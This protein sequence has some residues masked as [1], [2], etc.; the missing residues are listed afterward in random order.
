MCLVGVMSY[1]DLTCLLFM[2]LCGRLRF[3]GA[4]GLI[5]RACLLLQLCRGVSLSAAA[6][7]WELIRLA[8]NHM[9]QMGLYRFMFG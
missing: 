3:S 4:V 9:G 2:R 6:V 5:A 8:C 7:A 1:W